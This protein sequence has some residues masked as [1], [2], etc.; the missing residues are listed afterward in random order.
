[1]EKEVRD[2][3]V[4]VA[5]TSVIVDGRLT[6]FLSTLNEKVKVVIPEAVVAEIE[7]QACL[8]YTSPSPR[9]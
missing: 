6:Q 9:D 8:L 1:V 2:M 4:F 3:K 7:H 5:D